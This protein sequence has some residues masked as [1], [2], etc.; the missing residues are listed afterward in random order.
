MLLVI[1]YIFGALVAIEA[2]VGI[3]VCLY[4]TIWE[5]KRWKK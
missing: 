1:A 5:I 3:A 2:L 4:T